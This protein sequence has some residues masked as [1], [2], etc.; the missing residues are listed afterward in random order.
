MTF[1]INIAFLNFCTLLNGC[2][3]CDNL[4]ISDF[5]VRVRQIGHSI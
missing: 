3:D 5:H 2:G 4:F 1:D